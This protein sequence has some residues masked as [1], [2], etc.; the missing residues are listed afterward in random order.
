MIYVLTAI[1]LL[2]RIGTAMQHGSA[3]FDESFSLHYAS[4]PFADMARLIVYDVHPPLYLFLLHVWLKIFGQTLDMARLFSV[5]LGTLAIPVIYRMGKDLFDRHAGLVAAALTA[6]SPILLFHAGEARMYPLL[7]LLTALAMWAFLRVLGNADKK[8]LWIWGILSGLMLLTHISAVIPFLVMAGFAIYVKKEKRKRVILAITGAFAPFLVWLFIFVTRRFGGVGSEWQLNSSNASGSIL[9]RFTDFF[10][11]GSGTWPRSIAAALLVLAFLAALL[12]WK[13]RDGG[14]LEVGFRRGRKVWYLALTAAL[15]FLFF[16]PVHLGTVK[17]LFVG[18]SAAVLLVAAGLLKVFKKP[19]AVIAVSAVLVL[20]PVLHLVTE[21][22]I[23]WDGAMDFI[24]DRE[25]AGDVIYQ[26]W[27]V[28]ELSMRTY[29]DGSL[30]RKGA[31]P[32]DESLSFDERIVRHAGQISVTD[33]VVED[34]A[35]YVG[36]ADRVFLVTGASNFSK[37]PAQLWFFE[38]GW[39]LI[40]RYEKN[41]FSPIILLLE[42]P[43]KKKPR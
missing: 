5:L 29:Y 4:M 7:L 3:W 27:F 40:D 9:S 34:M 10:F 18:Y 38:Q 1:G 31:Y 28:S 14:K 32:Y 23:H 26:S 36:S 33:E 12:K 30:P 42:N 41:A 11:Y 24:E 43:A 15:P 39:R 8:S 19:W 25:H 35:E 2:L 17:Y 22:R 20:S 6:W 13:R 16:L 37:Q 21:K